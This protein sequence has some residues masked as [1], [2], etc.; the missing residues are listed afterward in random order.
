M[1]NGPNI[2]YLANLIGD[3]ARANMLTELI[4]GRALTATELAGVA[5]VTPQTASSHLS[6]LVDGGL[7]QHRKQG[8]HRYFA[9][10]DDEVAAVLE[11]LLSLAAGTGGARV[12]TGPKDAQLRQARVC[13]HHLAGVAGVRLYQSLLDQNLILE[14]GEAVSMT[15]KGQ[16]FLTDFGIDVAALAQARAPMCRACLDWSERRSHLAGSVGRALLS[17]IEALGWVVRTDVPRV[18]RFTA[19]GQAQFEQ[20]FPVGSQI[21]H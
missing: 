3:P 21:K 8:R 5:G 20:T 12:R 1:K 13:Y 6:K 11:G 19:A 10:A 7:L 18:I 15:P 9:L 14:N 2:A 4:D 17:R 16:Q